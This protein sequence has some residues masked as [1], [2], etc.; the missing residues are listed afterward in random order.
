V[1]WR[2]YSSGD[3]IAQPT[4]KTTVPDR[5]TLP[6]LSCQSIRR[7]R[8]F[9][10]KD[11]ADRAMENLLTGIFIIVRG[12]RVQLAGIAGLPAPA[13]SRA[14]RSSPGEPL[15]L[16]PDLAQNYTRTMP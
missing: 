1:A 10:L 4:P 6:V 8:D 11:V 14:P 15:R 7:R 12:I 16:E 5:T 3:I 9:Q 2:V 13:T